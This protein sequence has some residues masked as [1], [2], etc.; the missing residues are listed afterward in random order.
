MIMKLSALTR[1]IQKAQEDTLHTHQMAEFFLACATTVK[2]EQLNMWMR[3]ITHLW[4]SRLP[5]AT[6]E[7][8]H[9][10]LKSPTILVTA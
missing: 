5:R 2:A 3:Q 6:M 10:P 9:F 1:Q 4:I 8:H 7:Q